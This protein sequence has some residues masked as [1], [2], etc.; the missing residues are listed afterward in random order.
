MNSLSL[1]SQRQRLLERLRVGAC[2]TIEARHELDI[3][4]PAARVFELKWNLGHNIKT[5]WT[6]GI[7][8]GGKRHRIANYVLM[9]GKFG[10][11]EPPLQQ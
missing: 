11:P 1:E 4:S 10:D 8:P 2:S 7:N 9:P 5:F 3:I 6:Q